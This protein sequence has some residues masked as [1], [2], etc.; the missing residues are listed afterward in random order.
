MTSPT[1]ASKNFASDPTFDRG[2]ILRS[3]EELRARQ[4][5]KLFQALALRVRK[6]FTGSSQATETVFIPRSPSS[7]IF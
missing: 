3:A 4:V 5:R 2:Q 1:Y 7:A 6:A